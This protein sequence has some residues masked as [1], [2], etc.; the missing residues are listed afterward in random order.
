[1]RVTICEPEVLISCQQM[2]PKVA[3]QYIPAVSGIRCMH[4]WDVGTLD[5][6]AMKFHGSNVFEM[7]LQRD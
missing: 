2:A 5:I 4:Q 6:G 7:V 3:G 1:M